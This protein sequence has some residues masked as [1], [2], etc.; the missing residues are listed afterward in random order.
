MNQDFCLTLNYTA[1][2]FQKRDGKKGEKQRVRDT[3]FFPYDPKNPNLAIL[4]KEKH[5]EEQLAYS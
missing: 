2:S 5:S 4:N 3:V 1:N